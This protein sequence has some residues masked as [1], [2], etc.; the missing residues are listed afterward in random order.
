M[1]DMSLSPDAF[2]CHKNFARTH[3]QQL[4]AQL[5]VPSTTL[6][7]ALVLIWHCNTAH[8][9]CAPVT[10]HEPAVSAPSTVTAQPS[11]TRASPPVPALDGPPSPHQQHA[12][13]QLWQAATLISTARAS[14]PR[15]PSAG[16]ASIPRPRPHCSPAA[17]TIHSASMAQ[18]IKFKTGYKLLNLRESGG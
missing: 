18:A 11:P 6:P 9:P 16:V 12:H 5:N 4:E 2:P 14:Q 15:G 13:L 3:D 17:A 10:A 8:T 1:G 7:A